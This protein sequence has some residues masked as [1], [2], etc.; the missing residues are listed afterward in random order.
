MDRREKITRAFSRGRPLTT[1]DLARKLKVSRQGIHRYLRELLQA[2]V[3]LKLGPSRKTTYYVLNRE[4]ILNKLWKK[5]IFKKKYQRKGLQEDRVFEEISHQT[6]LLKPLSP[7]ARK[8]FHFAFTEMVNNA[9]DHSASFF[10]A[11]RVVTNPEYTFFVVA[12]TGVGLFENIRSKKKLQNER[13]A[14]QDL[15]KGKQTTQPRHHS[16]EGIFFTSK[17][18]DKFVI[19]SHHKALIFDNRL[20]DIFVKD[21]HFCK[22]TR[23][24]FEIGN[25]TQRKLE[26]VFQE[27]TGEDFRFEKTKIMV[28]LFQEG[29]TYISRSQAKRLLHSLDPFEEIIL[30]FQ[31]VE[32]IGQ[33]FADEVFRV[34]AHSHPQVKIRP[35]HCNENVTLMVERARPA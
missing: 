16:G 30:D 7:E 20:P 11:V 32:T 4:A 28:K 9:I 10:I 14:L 19:E 25:R 35:I 34:F 24:C 17:V 6:P 2:G 31:G 29:E 22:G 3:I 15:L 13:E 5:K 23:V 1:I 21:I 26:K 12:D 8:I 33:G 27:Y 18:A